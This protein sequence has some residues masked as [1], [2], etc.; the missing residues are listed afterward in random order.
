VRGQ[1]AGLPR[2]LPSGGAEQIIEVALG[3]E[4]RRMPEVRAARGTEPWAVPGWAGSPWP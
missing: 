2:V 4:Q 1:V 3:A